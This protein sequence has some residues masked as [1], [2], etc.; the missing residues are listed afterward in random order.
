MAADFNDLLLD[1][2]A[3]TTVKLPKGFGSSD[4]TGSVVRL[5]TNNQL[6]ETSLYFELYDKKGSA[7]VVTKATADNFLKYL[8]KGRYDQSIFHRS[9]PGFVLQGGGYLAPLA[10]ADEGGTVDPISTFKTIKN[11]PG[12]SNLRGTIAMAKLAGDPDSATSQWFV[13]VGDNLEL[14]TQNDGFTVFW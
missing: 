2:S 5:A 13:N 6:G 10:P 11:Q 7:N 9:V 3:Q 12:N 8:K 1:R 4:A 14:D